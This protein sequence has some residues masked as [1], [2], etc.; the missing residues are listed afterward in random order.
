[1]QSNPCR[2]SNSLSASEVCLL[3]LQIQPSLLLNGD[4]QQFPLIY[5]EEFWMLR[6]K[7]ISMNSTVE[8]VPLQLSVKPMKLWWM[9][10]QQQ[11]R[12]I[13]ALYSRVWM[14]GCAC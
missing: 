3:L 13:R 6:D 12:P 11:V 8:E 5:F 1:V 4:S 10:I 7:L 2:Q 14:L 9:Q